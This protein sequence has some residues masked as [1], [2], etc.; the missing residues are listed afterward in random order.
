MNA[1]SATTPGGATHTL[2]RTSARKGRASRAAAHR[3]FAFALGLLTLGVV[4][5]G[6]L[7]GVDHSAG[8]DGGAA[9]SDGG[10]AAG[11]DG[12]ALTGDGG[13]VTGDGGSVAAAGDLEIYVAGDLTPKTLT[14]G[15]AGQTPHEYKMALATFQLLRSA[16]DSAPV[17]V[18]TYAGNNDVEA[19]ILGRTLV[20]RASMASLPVQTYTHA[21]SRL[22][23]TRVTVD[24]T[25]H[26]SGVAIPGTLTIVG[27]YSCNGCSYRYT[28]PESGS[29]LSPGQAAFTFRSMGSRVTQ[30][31]ELPPL[32]ATAGGQVVQDTEGT[33]LVFPLP[34]PFVPPTPQH[35]TNPA[36]VCRATI[37]Y[38]VASSF[39]WRDE[40]R[41]GY[42]T[43][44]FDVEPGTFHYE[45]VVNFGATGYRVDLVEGAP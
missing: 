39:R 10:L 2:A 24:A 20:G 18:F 26:T 6:R 8:A 38:D 37:T 9:S 41:T 11:G 4:A 15:L 30:V 31:G 44:T 3:V 17:T 1:D 29:V 28:D 34:F 27:V 14:D 32:P 13:V 5:C 19:D 36:D 16:T 22:T 42:T 12:G 45:P 23:R 21:R 35:L 7:D 25:V 40:T 33:W 43:S